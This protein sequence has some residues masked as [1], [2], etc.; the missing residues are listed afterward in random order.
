M[1]FLRFVF[2]D[3]VKI[4]FQHREILYKLSNYKFN[5]ICSRVIEI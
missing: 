3:E 2:L 5:D 1:F 4:N